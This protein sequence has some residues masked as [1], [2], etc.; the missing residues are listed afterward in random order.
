MRRT[1][2]TTLISMICA[3]S[4]F[5]FVGC[6]EKEAKSGGNAEAGAYVS[7]DINPSVEFITSA[8]GIVLSVR[9]ANEDACVLLSDMSLEG[10]S[11]DK[12]V[13]EVTAEAEALGYLNTTNTDVSIIAASE[14]QPVEEKVEDLAQAG[15]E[16]GSDLAEIK[17]DQTAVSLAEEVAAY[18]AQDPELYAGLTVAKLKLAK[19]IMEFDPTFTVE[20][21]AKAR[22]KE[23]VH[24]LHEYM[25]EYREVQMEQLKVQMEALFAEKSA[26]IYAKIDE[27]YGEEYA[28]TRVLV[29]KL[30]ALEERFDDELD[31]IEEELERE[32]AVLGKEEP[33]FDDD[34]LTEEMKAELTALIGE[35]DVQTT[36]DLERIIRG[37]QITL[38]KIQL[39]TRLTEEQKA[40]IAALH[41]QLCTLRRSIFEELRSNVQEIKAAY[42][43]KKQERKACW[44]KGHG[45]EDFDDDLDDGECPHCGRGQGGRR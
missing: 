34:L 33:D 30:E 11:L 37:H 13:K 18:K 27:F 31:R 32:A 8:K 1:W 5:P 6:A 28:K 17:P 42:R 44:E 41:E 29:A 38:Y 2:K 21:A 26:E 14:E 25:E 45:R 24:I 22:T 43:Q 12:A 10:K 19:S 39:A 9:A 20:Q 4:V 15:V 40:E 35:N 16:A 3:F 23:L 7:I 36:E